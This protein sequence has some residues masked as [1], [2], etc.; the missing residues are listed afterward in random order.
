[1]ETE[2]VSIPHQLPPKKR[3]IRQE[4]AITQQEPPKKKI[5]NRYKAYT[6]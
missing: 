1:M 4:Q 3:P 5:K 2:E 6:Y